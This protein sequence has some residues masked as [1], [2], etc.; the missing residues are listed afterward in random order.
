MALVAISTPELWQS[1]LLPLDDG[2]SADRGNAYGRNGR[3]PVALIDPSQAP[4]PP[5]LAKHQ[6]VD[7]QPFAGANIDGDTW[8]CHWRSGMPVQLTGHT[9][10]HPV[11]H[12]PTT[13]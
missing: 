13:L 7:L 4:A 1:G 6:P 3:R 5:A 10:T 9:A 11:S 2:D 8:P 12:A